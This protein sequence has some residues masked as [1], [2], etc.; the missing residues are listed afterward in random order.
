MSATF[1]LGILPNR[2]M[3]DCI[4]M[5]RISEALGYAG[6]W[7]ADSHSIMRDAYSILSV[8]A[9]QTSKLLLATGVTLTVT[10]HPAVLANSWASLQ[11]LSG[12]RAICGIGVGE[13]AVHNLGLQPERLAALEHKIGVIRALLRGDSVEYEGHAIQMPWSGQSVPIVMA[14]SG[15]KS[16]QLA[17]RIADG[18][19]F[20]VGSDPR[21]VQ[22]ALD[23]IGAGAAQAGR[24]LADVKLYM[25]VATAVD[26]DRDKARRE[27]KGYASIAAGTVFATV[28]REYFGDELHADLARMKA[29][30]DYAA[31]GSNQSAHSDLLTD[32]IF[33]AI[34]VACTPAEAIER[35]SAL[36]QL[37]IDGFVW[38]AG[39]PDPYPYMETFARE[40]MPHV[41]ASSDPSASS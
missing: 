12:G 27:I 24:S 2:P 4:E 5:G 32:R 13:S 34:A 25:R 19:L 31:H 17:G 11:E 1:H 41:T 23:H 30:Y 36:A 38:P 15:P 21:L 29:A 39:M 20:Q 16:L 28:P 35:F 18:V 3:Q 37:G 6:V 14:S 7:V 22:Y 10:R 8:L 26:A 9:A 33:D 40:V